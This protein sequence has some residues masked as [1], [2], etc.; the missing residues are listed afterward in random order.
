M[1]SQKVSWFPVKKREAEDG[2][3]GSVGTY[4]SFESEDL[5]SIPR[6]HAELPSM[7]VTIRCN[8]SNGEVILGLTGQEA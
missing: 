8:S 4:L 7:V 3:H 2:D 1:S 6:T 5:D